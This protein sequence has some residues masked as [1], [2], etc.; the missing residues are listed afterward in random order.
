[1]QVGNTLGSVTSVVD[2]NTKSIGTV[3]LSDLLSNKHEV[4]DELFLIL[5]HTA[6]TDKPILLAR[7]DQRMKGSLRVDISKAIG[8]IVFVNHLAGDFLAQKL[9]KY[10]WDIG[11]VGGLSFR[12]FVR[13]TSDQKERC[14][15]LWASCY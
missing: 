5:L 10:G 2:D 4:A 3:L 7:N 15:L 9:V 6:E 12:N 8:S 14:G 13:H 1:M 11:Q